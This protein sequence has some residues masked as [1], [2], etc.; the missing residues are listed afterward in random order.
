MLALASTL[1][2]MSYELRRL[3]IHP[4]RPLLQQI[5]MWAHQG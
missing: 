1:P 4:L 3:S 2:C 5:G